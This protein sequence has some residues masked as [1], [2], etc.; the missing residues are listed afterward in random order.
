MSTPDDHSA[1]EQLSQQVD[2]ELASHHRA[3]KHDNSPF[4]P[5]HIPNSLPLQVK[6]TALPVQTPIAD[7]ALWPYAIGLAII[8]GTIIVMAAGVLL[9]S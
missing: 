3:A 9:K 1:D 8:I 4:P 7:P 6:P 2:A 5:L